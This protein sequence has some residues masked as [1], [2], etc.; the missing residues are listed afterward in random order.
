MS[1]AHFAVTAEHVCSSQN[2]NLRGVLVRDAN[3]YSYI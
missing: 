3:A 1:V 2:L